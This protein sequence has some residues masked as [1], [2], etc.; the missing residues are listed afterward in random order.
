LEG[1]ALRAQ[2]MVTGYRLK[3]EE[4]EKKN[5]KFERRVEER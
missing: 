1:E 3:L 5:R 2:E 4:T